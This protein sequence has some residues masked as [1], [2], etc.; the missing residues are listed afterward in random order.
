VNNCGPA[1]GGNVGGAFT[2]LDT[3]VMKS[4]ELLKNVGGGD[5]SQ[6]EPSKTFKS[7]FGK[8]KSFYSNLL[9]SSSLVDA[10]LTANS[11]LCVKLSLTSLYAVNVTLSSGLYLPLK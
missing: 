10:M 7:I 1:Q 8:H 2:P 6:N 3:I 5:T 4:D 9:R 11:V